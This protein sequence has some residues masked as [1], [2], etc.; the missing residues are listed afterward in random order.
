MTFFWGFI[1]EEAYATPVNNLNYNE[2]NQ[3]NRD[4]GHQRDVDKHV[5]GAPIPFAP[6]HKKMEVISDHL[7]VS[8]WSFF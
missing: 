5:E 7:E 4:I 6:P 2:K 8:R 3:S 1:K